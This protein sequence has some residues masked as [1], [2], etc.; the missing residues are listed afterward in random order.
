MSNPTQEQINEY[1]TL[2]KEKM[3]QSIQE[4]IAHFEQQWQKEQQKLR[5]T[6][7]VMLQIQ[8]AVMGL[9]KL[10]EQQAEESK[11]DE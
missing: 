4:Q 7:A 8:G 9:R 6:E 1:V 5:E 2:T 3:S 10:E 11:T